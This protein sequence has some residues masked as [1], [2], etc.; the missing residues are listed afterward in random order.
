MTDRQTDGQTDGQTHGKK[1]ICL[2]TL[3]GGDIMTPFFCVGK[4]VVSM[5]IFGRHIIKIIDSV[6][7][8]L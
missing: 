1:T 6:S 2:P 4:W 3:S 7:S 5:V 8:I